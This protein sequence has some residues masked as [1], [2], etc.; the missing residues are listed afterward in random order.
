M[1]DNI[2]LEKV[3]KEPDSYA[4]FQS[5]IASEALPI[6]FKQIRDLD[7]KAQWNSQRAL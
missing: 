4:H 7:L 3:E 2:T 5:L 1:K 6:G